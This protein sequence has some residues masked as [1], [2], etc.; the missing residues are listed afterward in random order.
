[1][2]VAGD[3]LVDHGAGGLNLARGRRDFGAAPRAEVESPEAPFIVGPQKLTFQTVLDRVAQQPQ[4]SDVSYEAD[5]P[6][7]LDGTCFFRRKSRTNSMVTTSPGARPGRWCDPPRRR[8]WSRP[9][10]PA[11]ATAAPAAV[12]EVGDQ[13]SGVIRGKEEDVPPMRVPLIRDTQLLDG[14]D[15]PVAGDRGG[16]LRPDL[17]PHDA[18]DGAARFGM[19]S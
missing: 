13:I 1:M 10:R 17:E 4:P 14:R 2:D 8:R 6:H 12:L 3:H 19:A 15:E 9:A 18:I 16:V 5:E 11:S 7:N